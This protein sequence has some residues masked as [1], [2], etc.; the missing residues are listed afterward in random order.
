MP[1][2]TDSILRVAGFALAAAL[3]NSLLLGS[4]LV[5]EPTSAA[6]CGG[7]ELGHLSLSLCGARGSAHVAAPCAVS[8]L[9]VLYSRQ[10]LLVLLAT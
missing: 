3:C 9:G 5:F 4:L 2:C 1:S 10:A 6:R 7:S 8:P